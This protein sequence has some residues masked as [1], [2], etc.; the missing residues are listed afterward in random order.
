MTLTSRSPR[1][2][3]RSGRGCTDELPFAQRLRD[4]IG[5]DFGDG[6]AEVMKLIVARQPMGRAVVG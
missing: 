3:P 6:T 2:P 1:P 4:V 5:L